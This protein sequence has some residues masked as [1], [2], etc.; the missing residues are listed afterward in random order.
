VLLVLSVSLYISLYVCL[1][2]LKHSITE[3]L[4]GFTSRIIDI[5]VQIL[6]SQARRKLVLQ[7]ISI[8]K[9]RTGREGEGERDKGCP[10]K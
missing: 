4:T 3:L 5:Q 1:S 6:L 8:E 9:E 7:I 10:I 2:M